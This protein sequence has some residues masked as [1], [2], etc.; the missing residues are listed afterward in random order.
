MQRERVVRVNVG[1][2][3]AGKVRCRRAEVLEVD[4]V[5]V[6]AGLVALDTLDRV[7]VDIRVLRLVQRLLR[8]ELAGE[9]TRMLQHGQL[10][11]VDAARAG[12]QILDRIELDVEAPQR[13]RRVLERIRVATEVLLVL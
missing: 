11:S 1:V 4:F 7:L 5:E 13:A 10:R 12:R 6:L 8:L 3:G 2:V 9:L